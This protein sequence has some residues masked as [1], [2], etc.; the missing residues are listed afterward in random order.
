MKEW[1][2]IQKRAEREITY[3]RMRDTKS[4][5]VDKHERVSRHPKESRKRDNRYQNERVKK[6]KLQNRERYSVH[7]ENRS[8]RQRY[9]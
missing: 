1:A 5:E 3:I 7:N 8:K 9:V 2:D 4:K 6:I